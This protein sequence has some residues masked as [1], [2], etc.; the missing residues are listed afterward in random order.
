MRGTTGRN[1]AAGMSGGVAY[2]WNKEGN[3]DYFCNMEMV[4]LLPVEEPGDEREL[5]GLVSAHYYHTGSPLA[6]RMMD[7]WSEFLPRFLKVMP[8]EYGAM[9][10]AAKKEK[11]E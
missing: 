1:F 8:S 11:S 7:R 9:L 6:R 4:E 3:F 10:N 5:H 2:V